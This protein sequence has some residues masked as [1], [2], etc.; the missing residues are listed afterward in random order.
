MNEL[1]DDDNVEENTR[2]KLNVRELEL[3][4]ITTTLKT[5]QG[6]AMIW[7]FLTQTGI[8]NNTFHPD[9]MLHACNAGKREHGLWL[10]SELKAANL[11]YYLIMLKENS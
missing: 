11:D 3:Y 8:F 1:T 7:R 2:K 10:E 4:Q 9:P 5:P 6:R